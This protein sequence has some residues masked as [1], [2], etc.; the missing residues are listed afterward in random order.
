MYLVLSL[1][2]SAIESCFPWNFLSGYLQR[3]YYI[4][5]P[6]YIHIMINFSLSIKKLI[7]YNSYVFAETLERVNLHIAV[8]I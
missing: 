4:K 1:Y 3:N 7:I 6:V 2:D 5:P 8:S